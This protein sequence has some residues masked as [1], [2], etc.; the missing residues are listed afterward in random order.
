MRF[1]ISV[2]ICDSMSGLWKV[3]QLN[4]PIGSIL[5]FEVIQ[6]KKKGLESRGLTLRRIMNKYGRLGSVSHNITNTQYSKLM[7]K[8]QNKNYFVFHVLTSVNFSKF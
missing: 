7:R 2:I 8:P 3:L 4:K 1:S 6:G 5:I